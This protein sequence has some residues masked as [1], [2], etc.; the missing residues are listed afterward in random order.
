MW[1]LFAFGSALFAGLTAILAKCGMKDMDSNLATALRTCV[2]L[3]FSWIMVLITGSLPGITAV[4]SE[5]WLFLILSGLATGASWLC[6]F[7]ALQIGSVNQVAPIDKSSTILTMI[8]AFLI[9]GEPLGFLSVLSILLMG[10]GTWLMVQKRPF[11]GSSAWGQPDKKQGPV[12]RHAAAQPSGK[13]GWLFFAL[14]S[15]V[16]AALTSI[17]GKVGMQEIDSNLGTAIRTCVVLV[18]AWL[19]VFLRGSLSSIRKVTGQNWMFLILSGC[20]TGASW[21]C[22]YRAL[23]EGPASVV[24]PIDK[25]SIL[26]TIAFSWIVFREKLNLRAAAG[27]FLLVAGTLLLLI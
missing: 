17:L 24:A 9:L 12:K 19:V 25:L 18:M 23:Q 14:A 4:S 27:L 2:V 3:V 10:A 11:T 20:A 1:I 21:L 13:R 6:Y 5:N 26:V 15:A 7:H 16:F 22:Y 8:L